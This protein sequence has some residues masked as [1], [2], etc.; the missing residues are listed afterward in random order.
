M[1]ACVSG[2]FAFL[3]LHLSF[4]SLFL[5]TTYIGLD[6][7]VIGHRLVSSSK[8]GCCGFSFSATGLCWLLRE[9]FQP[10]K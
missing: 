1:W 10:L 2:I 5:L 8:L 4:I 9:R 3:L 7:T 6:W